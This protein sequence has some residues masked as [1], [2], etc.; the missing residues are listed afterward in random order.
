[1]ISRLLRFIALVVVGLVASLGADG[2]AE[3]V[4][5]HDTVALKAQFRRP[6]GGVPFPHDNPFSQA[7][8]ELGRMLFFEPLLS[9]SG[10]MSCATCHNPGLSW[11]DGLATAVGDAGNAMP[12]RSPTMLN[13]AWLPRLGWDGKFPGIEEVTFVPIT[14]IANM[15]LDA[16]TALARIAA[17]P[18]YRAA[19]AAAFGSPEV[20]RERIE[21]ATAT[22]ERTLV[23]GEA[24]F[25]RW[26]EGDE[27]A[28][29]ETAK[30]GFALFTGAAGCSGCHSGWA[31]TDGSF[32]DIGVAEGDD[33]GRGRLFPSSE[34]LQYAFKT[35][36]LRDVAHRAPYMHDGSLPTLAAV[37]DLYDKGGIARPSR[38]PEIK[39]LGL[40]PQQKA[41]LL[42]FLETLTSAPSPVP[43]PVLPR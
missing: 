29:D 19:F 33:V 39:K 22:Y 42:S 36:T 24:P 15:G 34:K 28:I 5:A 18:G 27:T 21:Q 26:I 43:V 11:G 17:I 35:P 32:Q 1:M 10:T 38:S 40:S 13:I 9:K 37:I 3:T 7:K 25:D 8:Y 12:L 20:T 14:G 41:E 2:R 4:V 23:S 30:R 31:F 16:Q 6:A